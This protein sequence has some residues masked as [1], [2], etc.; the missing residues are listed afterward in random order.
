VC[1]H[2]SLSRAS[3]CTAVS[4]LQ[5]IIEHADFAVFGLREWFPWSASRY[6]CISPPGHEVLWDPTH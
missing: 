6:L 3:L 5:R 1:V 4:R 2:G